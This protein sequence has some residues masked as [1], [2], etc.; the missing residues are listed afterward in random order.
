MECVSHFKIDSQRNIFPL[1]NLLFGSFGIFGQMKTLFVQFFNS[2]VLYFFENS[3]TPLSM[4]IL[5][6]LT[7]N[8]NV[9]L[10]VLSLWFELRKVR[11]Y[12][13]AG[14]TSSLQLHSQPPGF[15]ARVN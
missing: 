10:K 5:V 14:I 8:D 6:F 2:K 11:K 1:T 15:W 13:M 7:A 9:L 4:L 12:S 3:N